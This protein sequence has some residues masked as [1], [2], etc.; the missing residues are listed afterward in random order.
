MNPFLDIT[1]STKNKEI[2]KPRLIGIGSMAGNGKT[3]ALYTMILGYI[4]SGINVILFSEEYGTYSQSVFLEFI[5][6]NRNEKNGIVFMC[7]VA[8]GENSIEFF[9]KRL[10][11]GLEFL[12][13]STVVII[14]GPMFE[15][16]INSFYYENEFTRLVLFEK[17]N[18]K[19]NINYKE[20]LENDKNLKT[21]KNITSLRNLA[22]NNNTHVIITNQHK[23]KIGRY[24]SDSDIISSSD[25]PL[26]FSCDMYIS[27]S[28][29]KENFRSVFNVRR[30]KDRYSSNSHNIKCIFNQNN[31]TFET[32]K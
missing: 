29:Q 23:N 4:Q 31:F 16:S 1:T 7:G 26:L 18:K 9:H 19:I 17:T 5:R 32:I 3:I 28:K 15:G 11:N 12:N 10:K 22:I 2:N 21:H 14:D 13:G 27:I 24:N 20:N 25:S 8:N 30:I 6:D